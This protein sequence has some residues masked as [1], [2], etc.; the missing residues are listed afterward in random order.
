[1]RGVLFVAAALVVAELSGE[2]PLA[3]QAGPY[4]IPLAAT[5]GA[6]AARGHARLHFAPSPFGVAVTADGR[7]SYDVAITLAGL[8]APATLGPYT[9]TVAWAVSPDLSQWHRL[10]PVGN[11]TSML[12][13]VELNKFLLVISAEARADVATHSGPVL[14]RGYSPSTWLQSFITHPLFRGVN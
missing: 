11:G 13:P 1:V 14:L 5:P 9:A 4:D 6:S 8:P 10:G 3:A 2:R 7:T 12:G